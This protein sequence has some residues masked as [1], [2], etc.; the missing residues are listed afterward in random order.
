MDLYRAIRLLAMRAT[1]KP[2]EHELMD[3]IYRWYSR[4]YFTPLTQAYDL[5]QEDILK[6]YFED[7]YSEMN[8]SELA[9]E[10][11]ELLE[12]EEQK[13]QRIEKEEQQAYEADEFARMVAEE[14]KTK[15]EQ[16]ELKP[17][18]S[19][20]QPLAPSPP[21]NE[22]MLGIVEKEATLPSAIQSLPPNITMTFVDEAEL[23][24][25]LEGFGVM[26][27]PPKIK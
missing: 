16:K 27:Q 13:Q 1:I 5:P 11:L 26:S 21:K 20:G 3:R 17:N 2:S 14:E 23:Q 9:Q 15:A 7:K 22:S 8:E 4:T 12:T 25:E 6:I 18:H 19:L 24:E 10:K